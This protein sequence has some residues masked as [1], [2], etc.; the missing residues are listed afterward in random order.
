MVNYTLPFETKAAK[1][2][3][4][5]RVASTAGYGAFFALTTDDYSGVV[6]ANEVG[7]R[8]FRRVL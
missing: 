1:G 7:P 6:M 3:A 8:H 2:G 5:W 4:T